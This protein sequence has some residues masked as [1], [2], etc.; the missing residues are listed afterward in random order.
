MKRKVEILV[1]SDLHL[2][3]FGCRAEELLKYLRG[4]SPG[5]V[6][7]NG[8]IID[9]WAFK[10][11]WFPESHMRVVKK[12]MKWSARRP[13]Y[14][15]TGNHDEAL[16]RY[17]PA[18]LG[19]LRLVDQ[20]SLTIDGRR[21][22]FLHGDV[23]DA[24]MKN[25]R[26]LAKLGGHGY[27]LLIRLNHV[28]NVVLV[29]LGRPRMSFSRRVK[30]SVKRAVNFIS[31]F[32]RTM[33]GMA[34]DKGHDAVVCGHI[35]QPRIGT[36]T[37]EKGAVQYLNSGDWIEN[38]TALEYDH[39]RWTLYTHAADRG[40]RARVI[41]RVRRVPVPRSGRTIQVK[42]PLLATN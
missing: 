3:T 37:T 34:L 27:D 9:I 20:L 1:L 32:E 33:A 5:T 10:K 40:R 39:G 42:T 41:E 16:R 35:H 18:R 36:I 29:S 22:W 6:I 8:D 21:H 15:I 12:L 25:A 7:L 28:V 24:T 11:S 30:N 38:L 14:Y 17:S 23:F 19:Q 26:W 2:G 31:D 4:V 13:V